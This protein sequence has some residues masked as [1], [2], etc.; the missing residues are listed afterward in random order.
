MKKPSEK[1]SLPPPGPDRAFPREGA[2]LALPDGRTALG[3]GPFLAR[4]APL[5]GKPAFFAPDF[6]LRD[7]TPWRHPARFMV[8]APEEAARLLPPPPEGK[9][10]WRPPDPA[11]FFQAFGELQ[12]EFLGGRLAKAVPLV[13]EEAPLP[14]EWTDRLPGLALRALQ[15]RPP[16]RAYAFWEGEAGLLGATPET[17]FQE[18]PGGLAHTMALA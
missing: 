1:T 11:P 6:F 12:E 4:K 5:P 14:P 15:A 17:L 8:L 9:P 16:S 7:E 18:G 10:A 3:L 2:L 13:F